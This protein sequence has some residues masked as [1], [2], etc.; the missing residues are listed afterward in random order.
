MNDKMERR[1]EVYVY[2]FFLFLVLTIVFTF[3][4][5]DERF[6]RFI[7]YCMGFAYLWWSK[8]YVESGRWFK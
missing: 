2:F 4:S 6:E 7:M 8:G 5:W 3:I 1:I